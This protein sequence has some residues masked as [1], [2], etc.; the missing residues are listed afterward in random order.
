MKNKVLKYV[1]AILGGA[2]VGLGTG[3]IL[4]PLKL[5]TGGFSGIATLVHYLFNVPAGIV[6]LVLNIPLFLVAIK[7]LGIQYSFR[8]F[9]SML[10][11]SLALTITERWN[12]LT[13]DLILASIF[14][15]AIVGVGLALSLRGEATT[16]GTDL[17]AKLIQVKKPYLNL[18]EIL[19]IIDG[20]II[21][22][23]SFTFESIEV[24]LYSGIAV[25]VMTKIMDLIL[26]GGGYAK[27]MF[28]ITDKE[29]EISEYI[30]NEVQRSATKIE[31]Q[32]IYSK[33]DK[34][35]LLCVA[36]KREIP[37]IKNKIKEIDRGCFIIITTVTEAIGTG[38]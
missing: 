5:S 24:A 10:S 2:I 28:I 29:E 32:G 17:I 38:F 26:E 7:M 16:G 21:A 8:A 11:L 18:G 30:I 19:L 31:A 14:G 22:I 9:A 12:P 15:G 23:S 25:F 35:I 34:N 36:N 1:L 27:A 6:T 13:S 37:K 3:W 20:L 33:K 4:L